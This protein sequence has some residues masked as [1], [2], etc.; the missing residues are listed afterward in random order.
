MLHVLN[1]QRRH[2]YST[3]RFVKGEGDNVI[4]LKV[5]IGTSLYSVDNEAFQRWNERGKHKFGF[6]TP[7]T[8]EFRHDF[9]NV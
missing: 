6:Y 9:Q 5:S 3:S 2:L 8:E 4:L 7:E 1:I